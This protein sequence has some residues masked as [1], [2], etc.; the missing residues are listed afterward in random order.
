MNISWWITLDCIGLCN[1][2]SVKILVSVEGFILTFDY[3]IFNSGRCNCL[4][5]SL[6]LDLMGKGGL[7]KQPP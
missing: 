4:T 7:L 6:S 2:E 1:S 3:K 5:L